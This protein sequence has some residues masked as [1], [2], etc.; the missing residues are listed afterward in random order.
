MNIVYISALL[1]QYILD[2]VLQEIPESYSVAAQKFHRNLVNGFI[3]NCHK[4]NVLTYLPPK[5]PYFECCTEED[6]DYYFCKYLNQPGLKHIQIAKGI[7][8][9]IKQLRD[10]GMKPDV[11][12]CDILN[13]SV[14][15]GAL[16]AG[17]C[18]QIKATGIVT[19]LL[20][21]SEHEE[22]GLVQRLAA[23]ISNSYITAFD[24]YIILT[25]QMN[26]VVNPH[27]RPYI[28]MEGLCDTK[29]LTASRDGI[30]KKIFYAGGRPSKDGIDLLIPAFKRIKDDNLQ[31][32]IYGNVPNV[33]IGSDPEDS[34][35]IYHGLVD[36]RVIVE[37]E[38]SSYLLVN[39]R[40]T[41]EEYTN[42]SFPSKVMEYMATGI[43]MVTTRLAGI[44]EE[45][46]DYVFTFDNC[47]VDVYYETLVKILSLSESYMSAKGKLAQDFVL[48]KKN[49]IAQTARIVE[50]IKMK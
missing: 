10:Q 20:G 46:Y 28:V 42:Y 45:Y 9:R 4:V 22:K 8:S 15:L 39:P 5:I 49:N 47:D 6:V 35:I 17:K 24:Y 2:E 32:N 40:P 50:L 36:N 18:L 12:I 43:P 34:R 31:L 21:I 44:P 25:Q 37:E 3:G 19:D 41:D 1:P 16:C 23:K 27:N 7:Y 30:L 29:K 13:V 48:N 33:Q 11:L 26:V 38:C 14:C